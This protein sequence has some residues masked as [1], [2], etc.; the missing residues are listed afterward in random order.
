MSTNLPSM[1]FPLN[2]RGKVDD[3]V[4]EALE[5]HDD[6]ITDLQQAIPELKSQIK[7]ATASTTSTTENVTETNQQTT[8]HGVQRRRR[9]Q[10]DRRHF[11]PDAAIGFRF[12]SRAR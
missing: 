5:Y 9:Q 1:R 11:V 2:V 3:S 10:S 8:G 6:A 4:A 7:S 12:S